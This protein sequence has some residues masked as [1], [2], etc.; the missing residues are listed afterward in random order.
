M[1]ARPLPKS[2]RNN[3]DLRVANLAPLRYNGKAKAIGGRLAQRLE[4][5]VHTEEAGGSNP[6]SPTIEGN[7]MLPLPP[8]LGRPPGRGGETA[9]ALR[10]GRS[11]LYGRV[12]SNPSLGTNPFR[13][14][15]GRSPIPARPAI[16]RN[17]GNYPGASALVA[18]WRERCPAEAEVVGSNPAKRA[19]S[20]P[21]D[22]RFS[23]CQPRRPGPARKQI[24]QSPT[25]GG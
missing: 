11:V 17:K 14:E 18:Q 19:I 16:L 6:P 1:A 5:L 22:G 9:D 12:G 21:T 20:L 10:S 7:L 13:K 23:L 2:N 25:A 4:R 8:V 24:R 15:T 3:D